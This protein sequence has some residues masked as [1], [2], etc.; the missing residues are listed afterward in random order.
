[1]ASFSAYTYNIKAQDPEQ[2][3]EYQ[4]YEM[5]LLGQLV[6]FRESKY[7]D[8]PAVKNINLLGTD[9]L[10]QFIL[11]DDNIGNYLQVLSR[12]NPDPFV[13]EL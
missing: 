3:P 1:M 12:P 10:N 9:F 6:F 13:Q 11:V 5:Q 8:N 7:S 2:K 4:K